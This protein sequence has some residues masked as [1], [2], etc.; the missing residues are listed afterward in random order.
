[1]KRLDPLRLFC[2][3]ALLVGALVIAWP[4]IG[5]ASTSAASCNPFCGVLRFMK[6]AARPVHAAVVHRRIARPV[7]VVRVLPPLRPPYAVAS[8]PPPVYPRIVTPRYRTWQ[9]VYPV[10]AYP[11]YGYVTY[12]VTPYGYYRAY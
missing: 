7:R 4:T 6:P 9:A 11:G 3:L 1:M 5:R 12:Y 10:Y 2:R 8:L